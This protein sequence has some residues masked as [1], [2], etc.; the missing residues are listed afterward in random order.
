MQKILHK[1]SKCAVPAALAHKV[2]IIN[3]LRI[4]I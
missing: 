1:Y 3:H 2:L 4:T